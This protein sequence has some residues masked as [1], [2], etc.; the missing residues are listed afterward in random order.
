M[1]QLLAQLKELTQHHRDNCTSYRQIVDLAFP[2][3]ADAYR[4][5]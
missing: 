2:N 3:T 4:V 5:G 1:T